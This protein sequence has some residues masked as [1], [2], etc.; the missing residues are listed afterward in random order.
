MCL[1]TFAH[2]S[3]EITG[4]FVFFPSHGPYDVTG[5]NRSLAVQPAPQRIQRFSDE[6]A[7]GEDDLARR[8]EPTRAEKRESERP[9]RNSLTVLT[10]R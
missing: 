6:A 9:A 2:K 5:L 3:W 8:D 10:R 1:L 4:F 7:R